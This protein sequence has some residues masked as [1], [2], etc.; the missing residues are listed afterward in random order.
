MFKFLQLVL[1]N[2]G[3]NRVRTI[4]TGL[5]VLVLTMIYAVVSKTTA[6]IGDLVNSTRTRV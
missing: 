2:L 5:A 6:F 4:L 1:K 3:R